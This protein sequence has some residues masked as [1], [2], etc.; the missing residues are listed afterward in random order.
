[1]NQAGPTFDAGSHSKTLDADGEVIDETWNV[2]IDGVEFHATI[3]PE[4]ESMAD[5]SKK[6]EIQLLTPISL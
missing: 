6:K 2:V 5:L 4:G 1:M 3:F